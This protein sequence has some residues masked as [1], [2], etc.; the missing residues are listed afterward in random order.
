MSATLLVLAAVGLL[1]PALFHLHLTSHH[2]DLAVE[3]DVSLEIA[4]VLFGAYIFTLLFSL[5]THKH[6]YERR[7]TKTRAAFRRARRPRRVVR[8]S[9]DRHRRR[10]CRRFAGG[11]PHCHEPGGPA[12]ARSCCSRP[13]PWWR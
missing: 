7:W 9:R 13:P 2:F 6:L 8:P 10:T 5:K 3:Q 4:L 1:T 11:G 12:R